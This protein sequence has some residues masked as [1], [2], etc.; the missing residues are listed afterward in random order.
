MKLCKHFVYILKNDFKFLYI[1]SYKYLIWAKLWENLIM[2][3]A[4]NKGT[5]QP[6]HLR[7]L[8]NAFIV[9]CLDCYNRNFKTLASLCSWAD[10]FESFLIT[11][12][13]DRFSHDK[14]LIWKGDLLEIQRTYKGGKQQIVD[15]VCLRYNPNS[16]FSWDTPLTPSYWL[17]KTQ[18]WVE[19]HPLHLAIGWAKLSF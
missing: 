15:Q 1:W 5:D 18:L 7:S 13:E 10:R 17:S 3:Y 16:A 6:V 11:N 4:N 14:A 9:R 2:L 12:P 8:I 19:I